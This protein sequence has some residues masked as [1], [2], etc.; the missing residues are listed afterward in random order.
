MDGDGTAAAPPRPRDDGSETAPAGPPATDGGEDALT[1]AATAPA[2][3]V[4]RQL[5]SS[6]QGLAAAEADRR[7]RTVSPNVLRTHV[8]GTRPPELD[9]NS[10]STPL[11]EV[12]APYAPTSAPSSTTSRSQTSPR[13]AFRQP[14]R[15]QHAI[16][17]PG[18]RRRRTDKRR[19]A[20]P[21]RQR[22]ASSSRLPPRAERS[23]AAQPHALKR[24]Q[25][26]ARRRTANDV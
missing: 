10:S 8:R 2:D 7:L 12:W 1:A 16:P 19:R 4:L 24:S 21:S 3:V 5:R 14:S 20:T 26:H 6:P 9:Y 25:E 15:R 17:R 22:G 23:A 18:S 13:T 11:R